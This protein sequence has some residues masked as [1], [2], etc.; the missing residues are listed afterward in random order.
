M[1]KY[2][3]KWYEKNKE[4]IRAKANASYIKKRVFKTTK[5]LKEN[6]LFNSCRTSAKRKDL[7]FNLSQ[8]DII[9]PSLCPIFNKPFTYVTGK[10]H[11]NFNPSIDRI[12]NS[13]GYIKGNIQIISVREEVSR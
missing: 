10:G 5:Q 4:K 6:Q 11:S 2:Q 3:K 8:E 7:E 9:I 1:N 13:K 12:D